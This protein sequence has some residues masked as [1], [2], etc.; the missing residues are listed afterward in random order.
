MGRNWKSYIDS[1]TEN[2]TLL[3]EAEEDSDG[4]LAELVNAQK[5]AVAV[6]CFCVKWAASGPNSQATLHI[7][8]EQMAWCSQDPV[9]PSPFPLYIL[10]TMHGVKLNLVWPA[11]RFWLQV[12]KDVLRTFLSS[13]EVVPYQ[14]K[15]AATKNN[16]LTQDACELQ[17]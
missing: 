15:A 12:Q 16:V 9:I 10:Q 2:I 3:E 13:E 5:A 17:K 8:D 7:F 4:V 11:T 1:P 6:R 14:V